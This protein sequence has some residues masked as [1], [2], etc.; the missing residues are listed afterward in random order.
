MRIRRVAIVCVMAAMAAGALYARKKHTTWLDEPFTKWNRRQVDKL[1]NN[2]PWARSEAYRGQTTGE[3]GSYNPSV[4]G[5]SGNATLGVDTVTYS[6]TARL[7]SSEPIREAYVRLL[8][9]MNH[10]DI[11]PAARQQAFDAKVDGLLHADVSTEVVVTLFYGTNDPQSERSL[12][13][14]F[15]TQTAD[16]LKQNAYL[17]TSS[18]GQVQLVKYFPAQGG[19]GLGARFIYPRAVNGEP[20]LQPGDS[21]MR[22]QMYIPQTGQTL[23]ID[24]KPSEMVYQGQLTY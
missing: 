19:G 9:I 23:R 17:Y 8:Q 16:T 4:T 11:M 1:F 10:Y 6:F 2:S 13:Q 12:T 24:F 18:A 7:F 3:H 21:M 5:T 14:W 20:I 15:G 22:F